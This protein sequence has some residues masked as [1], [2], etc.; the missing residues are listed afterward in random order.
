M[1]RKRTGLTAEKLNTYI[2]LISWVIMGGLAAAVMWQTAVHKTIVIEERENRADNTTEMEEGRLLLMRPEQREDNRLFIPLE[3]D[4]APDKVVLE[5]HYMDRELW[6]ILQDTGSAYYLENA[7]YGDM[8]GVTEGRLR[9]QDK[10]V[11]LVLEMDRVYEYRSVMEGGKLIVTYGEPGEMYRQ[12]VVVEPVGENQ[13]EREITCSVAAI[14]QEKLDQEGTKLYIADSPGEEWNPEA[15]RMLVQQTEADLYVALSVSG[16]EDTGQ[17]GIQSFYND[18]YFIPGFGNVELADVLTRNVTIAAKN[19][20]IGLVPVRDDAILGQLSVPAARLSMGFVTN[21]TE[22]ALLKQEAYQEK[23][24]QGIV[25]A[26]KE[27]YT[28][29]YEE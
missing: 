24:A 19:R 6:I 7:V 21:E 4:I 11:M 17:Y 20:A 1:K 9:E 22:Q 2:T 26:I 29:R 14:M 13:A 25:E 3:K 28:I 18:E 16:A 15:G 8:G 27:V 23:L 12:V 5:N 10:S